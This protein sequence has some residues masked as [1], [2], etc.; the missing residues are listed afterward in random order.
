MSRRAKRLRFV[1]GGA[2]VVGNVTAC[3]VT[4]SH[5][6]VGDRESGGS[7]VLFP[8]LVERQRKKCEMLVNVARLYRDSNRIGLN[9]EQPGAVRD[10][11]LGRSEV[12]G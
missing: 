8:G 10:R 6:R 2:F 9:W 12:T 7:T 11:D 4:R 3:G 5:E 1:A